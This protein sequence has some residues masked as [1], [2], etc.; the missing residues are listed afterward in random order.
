MQRCFLAA[1]TMIV[2]IQ[3]KEVFCSYRQTKIRG[4]HLQSCFPRGILQVERGAADE[5]L[6]PSLDRLLRHAGKLMDGVIFLYPKRLLISMAFDQRND[7]T[8]YQNEAEQLRI[9]NIHAHHLPVVSRKT[10]KTREANRPPLV[11]A[12]RR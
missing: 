8:K 2:R 1:C 12:P 10:R 9:S 3:F 5:R 11:A 6:L 4:K 7:G